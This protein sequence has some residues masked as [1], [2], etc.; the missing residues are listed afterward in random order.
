MTQFFFN[1]QYDQAKKQKN[2]TLLIYLI[3]LGVYLFISL[4]LW[5]WFRTLPYMS[6][7]ITKIKFIHYPITAVFVIFSFIYLGIKYKRINKYFK[8]TRNLVT[9]LKETSTGSFFEYDEKLRTKDGVDFKS[10]VFIE[11]NKYKDDF[12]E[13]HVLVLRDMQFPQ[14]EENQNVKYVTQGNVLISYEILSYTSAYFTICPF[15]SSSCILNSD[16]S[17]SIYA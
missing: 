13:R 4:G 11:W 17:S 1:S 14:F 6:K 9:G 8:M 16:S 2:R 3:I 7:D 5:L 15:T 10:L 12:Y